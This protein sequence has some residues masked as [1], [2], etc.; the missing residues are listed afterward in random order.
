MS[1]RNLLL[2]IC[3][4]LKKFFGVEN[5][6]QETKNL[7]L[8]KYLELIT[9]MNQLLIVSSLVKINK[10]KVTVN[11]DVFYVQCVPLNFAT[12]LISVGFADIN[13]L[14]KSKL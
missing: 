12:P 5:I 1:L 7:G 9:M 14:L 4:D 13:I 8:F 3:I 6:G 10:K 11:C 2:G